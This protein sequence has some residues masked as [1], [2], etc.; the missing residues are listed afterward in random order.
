MQLETSIRLSW[1]MG[2]AG[3]WNELWISKFS[4]CRF[5]SIAPVLP[6]VGVKGRQFGGTTYEI[7]WHYLRQGTRVGPSTPWYQLSAGLKS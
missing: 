5:E 2:F 3:S 6:N 7:R 4:P 1:I